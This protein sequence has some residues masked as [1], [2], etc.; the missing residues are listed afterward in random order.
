MC[1]SVQRPRSPAHRWGEAVQRKSKSG[2]GRFGL[3]SQACGVGEGGYP[4]SSWEHSDL[5]GGGGETWPYSASESQG[6]ETIL[7]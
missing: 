3:H 5:G 1:P 7:T 4:G 2:R 6:E